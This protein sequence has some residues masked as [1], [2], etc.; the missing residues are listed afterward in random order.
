MENKLDSFLVSSIS[1]NMALQLFF[2]LFTFALNA[3]LLRFVST[4]L[5]GVCN[6]RLALLYS[7]VIFLSRE[8]FRRAMPS[9]NNTPK[10]QWQQ[11]INTV[12]LLIPSGILISC[13]FGFIW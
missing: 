4:E 3:L 9:L 5:I 10:H 1:Y 12:W 6:F 2:R 8:P 13:L 11:F 7:T